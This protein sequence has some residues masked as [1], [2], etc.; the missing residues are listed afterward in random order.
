MYTVYVTYFVF[1]FFVSFGSGADNDVTKLLEI[2]DRALNRV[3]EELGQIKPQV[4]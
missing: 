3:K 4:Q 1:V 2:S